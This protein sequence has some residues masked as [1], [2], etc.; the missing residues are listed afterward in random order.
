MQKYRVLVSCLSQCLTL[1]LNAGLL[2][3]VAYSLI[4]GWVGACIMHAWVYCTWILVS[5]QR[6]CVFTDALT[7]YKWEC[8]QTQSFIKTS[9][10]FNFNFKSLSTLTLKRFQNVLLHKC[11]YC[12]YDCAWIWLQGQGKTTEIWLL[13]EKTR[14]WVR[15][16]SWRWRRRASLDRWVSGSHLSHE[17]V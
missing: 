17:R 3:F 9:I 2:V 10:S 5:A 6:V 11:C 7:F 4:D 14:S 13:Q 15:K 8:V 1:R 12:H 16:K